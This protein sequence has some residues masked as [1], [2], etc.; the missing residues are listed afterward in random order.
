[1]KSKKNKG[2]ELE[3]WILSKIKEFDSKA[4]L[5]R[6]SGNGND[7]GDIVSSL[8]YCECKN[9]DKE[10]VILTMKVYNHLV[11]QLPIHSSKIPIFVHQNNEGKRFITLE[12]NDFFRLLQNGEHYENEK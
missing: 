12:A 9:H 5:S 7:I 6:G 10:N 11:N 1:M 2:T 4:R 3:L 8:F